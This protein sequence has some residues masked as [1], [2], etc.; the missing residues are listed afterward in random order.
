[1]PTAMRDARKTTVYDCT[2]VQLPVVHNEAGNITALN[3]A[4]EIPFDVKRVYYLYDVPGGESRGGHGHKALHQLILAGSGSFDITVDDGR[5]RRTFQL[6]RP[7]YG[8]YL[9]PG[10]WRELDNFSSG[11]ICLVVASAFYSTEDYIRNYQSFIEYK[12]G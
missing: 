12:K 4:Q 2:I 9:P 5:I 7:D 3:N 8:L 11:S 10:L 6:N 1:M